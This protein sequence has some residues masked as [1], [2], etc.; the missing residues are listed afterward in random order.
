MVTV[1]KNVEANRF[2][3]DGSNAAAVLT[4][5]QGKRHIA[6][7]HTEVAPEL[8]GRGYAGALAKTALDFARTNNLRVIVQCPFVRSY[9]ERHPEYAD[10]V[11]RR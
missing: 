3:V 6:L 11:E 2:E 10:L 9:L 4:Y 1:V 8:G 5:Y 7:L